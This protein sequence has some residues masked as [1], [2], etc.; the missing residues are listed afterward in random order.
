MFSKRL[1]PRLRT[2]RDMLVLITFIFVAALVLQ[3]HPDGR[4]GLLYFSDIVLPPM[5]WS[6]EFFGVPCPGCGLTRS[7]VHL[8]HGRLL[9]SLEAHRLGWLIA[10]L[11]LAQIPYHLYALRHPRQRMLSSRSRWHVGL[12]VA[13]LLVTSWILKMLLDI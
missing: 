9:E 8:A 10:G 5:C 6:R 3:V 11:F 1:S 4:V 13:G 2:H 12:V 7:F